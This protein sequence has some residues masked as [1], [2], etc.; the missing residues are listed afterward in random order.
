MDDP[1]RL[2]LGRARSIPAGFVATYGDL[3]PEAPRLAGAILAAC[4][5]RSVPWHRVV[6]ADGTL[7][8]GKRQRTLLEAEGVPFRGDR[9]DLRAAWFAVERS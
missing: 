6:R 7:A 8:V 5:D 1:E 2:I 9:V 3:C 4:T